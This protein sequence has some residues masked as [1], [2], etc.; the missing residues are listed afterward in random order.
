MTHVANM[1]KE[2]RR[3]PGRMA[4]R[5]TRSRHPLVF[6]LTLGLVLAACR[7][8]GRIMG[9]APAHG[10]RAVA[11]PADPAEHIAVIVMENKEY[12]TVIGSPDAPYLNGLARRKVLLK[13]EYAVS[14][15]SLPNYL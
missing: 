10:A 9:A 8:S 6:G 4:L 2:R 11:A 1:L 5:A 15:P 13:Q 7:T 3:Y 14:H 12:G